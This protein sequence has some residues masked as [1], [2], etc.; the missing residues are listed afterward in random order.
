MT[1]CDVR[2]AIIVLFQNYSYSQFPKMTQ[3]LCD[4][5][6]PWRWTKTRTCFDS[7]ICD[8]NKF[9]IESGPG[10]KPYSDSWLSFSN[11]FIKEMG[12]KKTHLIPGFVN[13]ISLS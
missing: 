11:I 2:E 3:L 8:S 12:R 9:I 10:A 5:S 4:T 6:L 13:Q 1:S 7:W